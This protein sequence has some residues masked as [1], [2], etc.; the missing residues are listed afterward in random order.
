MFFSLHKLTEEQY[1]EMFEAA[2]VL[3]ER[4]R[5]IGRKAP[6]DLASL[7]KVSHVSAADED[8]SSG[9]VCA[10]LASDHEKI[11]KRLHGLVELSESHNDP[12]TAD[13]ATER[14]AFHEQAVW[15]LRAIAS[16]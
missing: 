7:L 10:E 13:L 16:K 2:D 4:I 9:E 12:V 8:A 6:T 5:A 14:S 1:G 3:A 15:M 11:S